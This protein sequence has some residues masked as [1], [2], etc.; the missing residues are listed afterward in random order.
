LWHDDDDDSPPNP[1]KPK[2]T[3]KAKATATVGRTP[4]NLTALVFCRHCGF[5]TATAAV[6]TLH[7]EQKPPLEKRQ[8]RALGPQTRS[9]TPPRWALSGALS[10]PLCCGVAVVAGASAPL[11]RHRHRTAQERDVLLFNLREYN[12]QL[13]RADGR[14]EGWRWV[15]VTGA[16]AA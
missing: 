10:G 11:E 1:T 15:A 12:A 9:A 13:I 16:A 7:R 2:A 6:E 14:S 4:L 3:A 5:S 8:S